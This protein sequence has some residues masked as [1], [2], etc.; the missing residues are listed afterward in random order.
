[1]L[2]SLIWNTIR[3]NTLVPAAMAASLMSPLGII[4][5]AEDKGLLA[6]KGQIIVIA[7]LLQALV[8]NSHM[9]FR[10]R[11][12]ILRA[13]QI[14]VHLGPPEC[15]VLWIRKHCTWFQCLC[16]SFT[17]KYQKQISNVL[18]KKKKKWY[19][20]THKTSRKVNELGSDAVHS[21]LMLTIMLQNLVAEDTTVSTT[22][23]WWSSH[24]PVAGHPRNP[25]TTADFRNQR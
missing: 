21:R 4:G 22:D 12:P 15:T 8:V 11:G 2:A 23:T 16:L 6:F 1:M 3:R 7:W 10:H 14:R 18:P 20:V 13:Y 9:E 19:Q 24:T 25:G 5:T 17:Y